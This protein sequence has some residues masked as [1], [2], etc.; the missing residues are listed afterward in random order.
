MSSH[1]VSH[2][3]SYCSADIPDA[4][5]FIAAPGRRWLPSCLRVAVQPHRE[6]QQRPQTLAVIEPARVVLV[7]Q[8]TNRVRPEPFLE[9]R[10]VDET[11][12]RPRSKITSQPWAD[13]QTEPLL[14]S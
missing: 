4:W 11:L 14:A 10:I 2:K 5:S 12:S 9:R 13:W 8:L 7:Q 1:L 3:R 6:H